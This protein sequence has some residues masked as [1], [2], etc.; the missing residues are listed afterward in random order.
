MLHYQ[1]RRPIDVPKSSYRRIIR[2]GLSLNKGNLD[3][4][5]RIVQDLK[6][7]H[8]PTIDCST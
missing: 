3:V 5:D 7:R 4:A 6:W 8:G 2:L 1:V